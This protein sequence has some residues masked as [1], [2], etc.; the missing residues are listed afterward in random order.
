MGPS[1]F[2]SSEG[3]S[4]PGSPM[5]GPAGG[6]FLWA[7]LLLRRLCAGVCDLYRRFLSGR[8]SIRISGGAGRWFCLRLHGHP[9]LGGSFRRAVR[10][11]LG[12]DHPPDVNSRR[13][14]RLHREDAQQH[15]NRKS[16]AEKL[17][18][19]LSHSDFLS[20]KIFAGTK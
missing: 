3:F 8:S 20:V 10:N 14:Q 5:S 9:W 15:D 18:C 4:S 11:L 17:L 1:S 13:R 7:F 2:G 6:G 16:R 12:D 19:F